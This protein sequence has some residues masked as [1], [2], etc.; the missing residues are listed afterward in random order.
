[1]LRRKDNVA[2]IIISLAFQQIT[3]AFVRS[4]ISDSNKLFILFYFIFFLLLFFL[5]G[6]F[7]VFSFLFNLCIRSV[8]DDVIGATA[9]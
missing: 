4:F 3:R 1:M 5:F 6:L 8:S 9:W 2:T 7:F